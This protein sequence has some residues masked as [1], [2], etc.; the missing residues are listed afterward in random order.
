MIKWKRDGNRLVIKDELGT[1][2]LSTVF[3]RD[4]YC[5]STAQ[6]ERNIARACLC[7]NLFDELVDL[8]RRYLKILKSQSDIEWLKPEIERVERIVTVDTEAAE[9]GAE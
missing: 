6:D 5:T 9:G 8:S 3:H 4:G 2:I 1:E 7:N